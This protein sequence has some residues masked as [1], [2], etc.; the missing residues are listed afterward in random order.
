MVYMLTLVVYWWQM[1]PYIYIA[2]P[3]GSIMAMEK[4]DPVSAPPLSHCEVQGFQHRHHRLPERLKIWWNGWSKAL[5]HRKTGEKDWRIFDFQY[6][7]DS[8]TDFFQ[9]YY[10]DL[11]HLKASQ[12]RVSSFRRYSPSMG[13]GI[14]AL[15]E[16]DF[17][18]PQ[19]S[20]LSR[21]HGF[22]IRDLHIFGTI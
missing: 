1:L 20:T 17:P 7:L 4:K 6:L 10:V 15:E 11:K 21:N 19:Y 8:S 16:L 14:P 9:R 18:S 22:F 12:S 5:S 2:A 3:F 13:M